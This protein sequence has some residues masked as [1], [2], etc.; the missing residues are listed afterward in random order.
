MDAKSSDICPYKS[1]TEGHLRRTQRGGCS[2]DR[3]SRWTW[4]QPGAPGAPGSR[5][6]EEGAP[7]R[8]SRGS[9]A[10]SVALGHSC[11]RKPIDW[12]KNVVNCVLQLCG[13]QKLKVINLDIQLRMYPSKVLKMWSS[14][15]L[16][17]IIRYERRE[18]NSGRNC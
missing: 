2:G 17:P 7:A 8:A 4:S 6:G 3:V 12:Q 13:K 18:M 10:P 9:T 15:F 1:E 16:L 11:R 5:R 14:F